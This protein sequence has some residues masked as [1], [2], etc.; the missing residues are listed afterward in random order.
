MFTDP[1]ELIDPNKWYRPREVVRRG[2][3]AGM[4]PPNERSAYHFVL[5]TIKRQ[6]IKAKDIS[7]AGSLVP[8]YLIQGKEILRFLAV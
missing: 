4:T 3:L 2:F 1:Y 5:G 6:D 7:R 8:H